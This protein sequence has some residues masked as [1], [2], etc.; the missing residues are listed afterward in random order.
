MID[1]GNSPMTDILFTYTT[2]AHQH[3]YGD[4]YLRVGE[5]LEECGFSIA[6]L[7]LQGLVT[8]YVGSLD[9]LTIAQQISAFKPKIIISD[10]ES[11]FCEI[12]RFFSGRGKVLGSQEREMV[13]LVMEEIDT[14]LFDNYWGSIQSNSSRS[15]VGSVEKKISFIERMR[16]EEV[17]IPES[18]LRS[19]LPNW[20]YK[21]L[22]EKFHSNH[23][24]FILKE[25]GKHRSL[26]VHFIDSAERFLAYGKD[27]VVAQKRVEDGG[28]YPCSLR[29]LT[30]GDSILGSFL[31][32][33]TQDLI[34][35]N[36][37]GARERIP[38]CTPM[39]KCHETAL[40]ILMR[41]NVD[42]LWKHGV[43][44][45]FTLRG[46]VAAISRHIG[47][48]ASRSVLRG[49]DFCFDS[50][51]KPFLLEAQTGPG[52]LRR[53]S[54]LEVSGLRT[55]DVE[56]NIAGAVDILTREFERLLVDG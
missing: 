3:T 5:K 42:Y 50:L 37:L 55:G 1:G 26:G 13:D 19:E 22:L 38:L 28:L 9:S 32:Y 40:D 6:H 11:L 34:C 52:N 48:M 36:A 16:E 51:G 30:F 18:V 35:S 8:E 14:C 17:C 45:D 4:V 29:V 41:G 33:H 12:G 53:G 49:L 54:L 31:F 39:E 2:A 44:D 24:G 47:A 10:E 25:E 46:D 56:Y 21:T 43:L 27:A 20:T 23:D 15:Y 7:D